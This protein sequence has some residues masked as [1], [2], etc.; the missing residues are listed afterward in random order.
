ML[1]FRHRLA[2][3][4][5]M[6]ATA[7]AVPAVALAS[8]PGA[9]SG[10]PT[11]PAASAPSASKSPQAPAPSPSPSASKSASAQSQL[12]ALA[13]SAGISVSQ[14]ETG[15]RAAKQ[16][17]ANTAAAVAAFAAATGVSHATA[18]RVITAVFGTS[19]S[20]KPTPMKS[21][22]ESARESAPAPLNLTGLAASAKISVN[23]LQAGLV[24]MKEAGGDT[25]AGIAAFARAS[26]VSHATAQRIATAVTHT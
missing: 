18:Q 8:G 9:P 13:A 24:A 19:T 12:N 5:V 6:T 3:A 1:V 21:S 22:E 23:Q 20:G 2:V 14:L 4:G 25:T 15:L 26:G 16:A 7:I 17:G 11:P 10:K